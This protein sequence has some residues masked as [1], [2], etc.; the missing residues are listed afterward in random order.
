MRTFSSSAD[1][2]VFQVFDAAQALPEVPSLSASGQKNSFAW[3]RI[4]KTDLV[5]IHD[6]L[7][8]VTPP[9]V[10]SSTGRYYSFD[11]DYFNYLNEMIKRRI[12]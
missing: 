3:P 1:F 4:E 2:E 8:V 11:K 6:M 7:V 10:T 9:N 5:P 12:E